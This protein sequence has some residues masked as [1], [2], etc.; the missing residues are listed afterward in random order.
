MKN[1]I[2]LFIFFSHI[3]VSAQSLQLFDAEKKW[4]LKTNRIE[5]KEL[6]FVEFNN[7]K[8]DV[9]TMI[10]TF[11]PNGRIEYDY[12]SS[13]DVY[14]CLG[15]D[16]IDLDVTE[17]RWEYNPSDFSITFLIKGGY[18]SLDDFVFKRIYKISI[19]DEDVDYG[20][21]LTQDKEYFFN[22]LSRSKK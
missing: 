12:Q 18:A 11:L 20:Y 3:I 10:W 8:V 15:V 6:L 4:I 16:F 19:L 5:K 13:D 1:I 21:V 22:D 9:N 2:F 17:C 7:A 14:A